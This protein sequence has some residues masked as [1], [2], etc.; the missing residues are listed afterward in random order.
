MEVLWKTV[1]GILNRILAATI[2]LHDTLHILRTGRGTG[3]DY[4]ES[5]LIQQ[6]MAMRGGY[7]MR[8]F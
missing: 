4:L 1:T 6:M 8:Y 5:N 2:Q 3:N 7:F